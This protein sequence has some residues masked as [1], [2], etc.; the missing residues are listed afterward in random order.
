MAGG[1]DFGDLLPGEEE[2]DED[3]DYLADLDGLEELFADVPAREFDTRL[4]RR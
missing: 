4:R 3:D 2:S 1:D